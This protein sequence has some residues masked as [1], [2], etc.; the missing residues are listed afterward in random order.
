MPHWWKSNRR[1]KFIWRDVVT[2]RCVPLWVIAWPKSFE[3]HR[4]YIF[5]TAK[6]NFP[7]SGSQYRP[8]PFCCRSFF[9]VI[10]YL[11]FFLSRFIHSRCLRIACPKSALSCEERGIFFVQKVLNLFDAATLGTQSERSLV[12]LIRPTITAPKA[13]RRGHNAQVDTFNG[14]WHPFLGFP[15]SEVRFFTTIL[16]LSSF[17]IALRARLHREPGTWNSIG[18]VSLFMSN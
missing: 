5:F 2:K 14:N 6:K 18:C 9:S 16:V 11:R 8:L 13:A 4:K 3:Q 15:G 17:I 7:P 1:N 12:L 10:F